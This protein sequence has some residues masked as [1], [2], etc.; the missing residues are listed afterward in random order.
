MRDIKIISLICLVTLVCLLAYNKQRVGSVFLGQSSSQ[1]SPMSMAHLNDACTNK[2]D[3][4]ACSALGSIIKACYFSQDFAQMR[5]CYADGYP[6]DEALFDSSKRDIVTQQMR[7]AA[8]GAIPQ[9]T[10]N[11]QQVKK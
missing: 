2:H 3:N 10:K 1:E 8:Y 11:A 6:I 7:A 5:A 4:K 9:D